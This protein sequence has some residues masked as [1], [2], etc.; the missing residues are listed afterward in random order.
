MELEVY[1]EVGLERSEMAMGGLEP[2]EG[3]CLK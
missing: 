3:T 2:W 1:L